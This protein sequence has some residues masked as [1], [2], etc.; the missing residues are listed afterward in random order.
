MANLGCWFI[1]SYPWSA[2]QTRRSPFEGLFAQ[3]QRLR[4]RCFKDSIFTMDGDGQL[5]YIVLSCQHLRRS[6]YR[7]WISNR[8]SG[9]FRVGKRFDLELKGG[10][11][12][13]KRISSNNDGKNPKN[14]EITQS[15]SGFWIQ[16]SVNLIPNFSLQWWIRSHL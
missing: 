10:G 14:P 8:P 15:R 2:I 4:S 12:I 6:N 9:K 7:K 13:I 1:Q 3:W 16:Y 11:K 5:K